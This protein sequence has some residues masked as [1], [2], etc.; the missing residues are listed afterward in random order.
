[1]VF[2]I[3]MA[4]PRIPQDPAYH[5]MADQRTFGGIPNT[6][7][8][9]SNAPFL[10]LGAIGLRIAGSREQRSLASAA[11]LT[12]FGATVATAA[13]SAYYHLL[14][15]NRRV[16]W[17]RLPM[18]VAF[19]SLLTAI[20]AERVDA[21]LGRLVFIPLLL[22]A[23][24][25]VLFWYLTEVAGHGDLRPYV[26]VQFGSLLILVAILALYRG[27][28]PD[29]LWLVAGL[30]AY[31]AAKFCEQFDARIYSLNHVVSGHTLKHVAASSAVGCVA[32]ML[33]GRGINGATGP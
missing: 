28:R 5:H 27:P 30:I 9:L 3:A 29:T 22:S 23:A 10:L 4:L 7:D 18:A 12:F 21:R 13:G 16:L 14:P 8:V 24:G 17:D 20:V 31:A 1:M 11:W 15:S 32:A 26:A 6:F 19:A 33:S 25:S 2:A